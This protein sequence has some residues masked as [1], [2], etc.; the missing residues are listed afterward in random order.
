MAIID[1]GALAFCNGK[2]IQG[3]KLFPIVEIGPVSLEFCKYG[4]DIRATKSDILIAKY[5]KA[6]FCVCTP[7]GECW[8]WHGLNKKS[9]YEVFPVETHVKE[10]CDGVF[11]LRTTWN[12]SRYTVIY[13][14]GIDNDPKIWNRVKY[15]YHNKKNVRKIERAIALAGGYSK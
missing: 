7:D 15:N 14:L 10:I 1:Y 12:G 4:C 11:R 13:G 9:T 8:F 2:Q 5:Y 3:D 6:D